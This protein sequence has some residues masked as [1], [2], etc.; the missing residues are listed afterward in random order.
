LNLLNDFEQNL[1]PKNYDNLSHEESVKVFM[2]LL[3]DRCDP[4]MKWE[5]ALQI[6]KNDERLKVIKGIGEQRRL[7]KE[8]INQTK[9]QERQEQKLRLQK[10]LSNEYFFRKLMMIDRLER[11]LEKCWRIR[12]CLIQIPNIIKFSTI[13]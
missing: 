5:Q 8:W 3:R 2:D 10:V 11:I 6:I 12:K 13:L 1:D 4:T 7:F 9:A